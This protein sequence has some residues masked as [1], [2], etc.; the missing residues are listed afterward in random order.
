MTAENRLHDFCNV[1]G[2]QGIERDGLCATCFDE[3]LYDEHIDR[4]IDEDQDREFAAA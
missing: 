3:F 4:L 2:E 1:C